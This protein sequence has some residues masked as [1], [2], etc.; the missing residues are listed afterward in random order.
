MK[1]KL[2]IATCLT[3]QLY[4]WTLPLLAQSETVQFTSD[5]Y[6]VAAFGELTFA[7][8]LSASLNQPAE[9][10]VELLSADPNDPFGSP[11]LAG[12][13]TIPIGETNQI[14]HSPR[15]GLGD[16]RRTNS[17]QRATLST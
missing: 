7:L 12:Y 14:D 11:W 4:C 17:A 9:I 6:P 16:V 8:K 2:L 5:S 1:T 13:V 3:L 15:A 10:G